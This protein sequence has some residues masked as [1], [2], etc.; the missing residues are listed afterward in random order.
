MTQEE[1]SKSK[2]SKP[3][4]F[5]NG[6]MDEFKYSNTSAR[7]STFLHVITDEKQL[8]QIAEVQ[9]KCDLEICP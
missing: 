7:A 4:K 5:I 6:D 2:A 8:E 9:K 1:F 3:I